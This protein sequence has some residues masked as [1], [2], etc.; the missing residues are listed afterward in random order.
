MRHLMGCLA[1][2]LALGAG[3]ANAVEPVPAAA[4][5]NAAVR[6]PVASALETRRAPL[7]GASN[8]DPVRGPVVS[9]PQAYPREAV[10]LQPVHTWRGVDA[11]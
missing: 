1:I 5:S 6:A 11:N 9:N 4:V 3:A 10:G 7:A 2:V 8:L